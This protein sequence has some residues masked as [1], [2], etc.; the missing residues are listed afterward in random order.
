MVFE[1]S[2]EKSDVSTLHRED[3]NGFRVILQVDSSLFSTSVVFQKT[4][5]SVVFVAGPGQNG[6]VATTVMIAS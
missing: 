2:A 5:L 4:V 3:L 1:T 6:E